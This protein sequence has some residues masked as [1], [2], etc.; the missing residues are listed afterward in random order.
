MFEVAFS[1][2]MCCS[3]VWSV[4]TNP[5]LPSMSLVSPAIRPGIRRIS[6]SVA[7]KNPNDGPPKSRRLPSVWPSPTAMSTPH[8]PGVFSSASGS[9]SHAQI[10]SAPACLA[11][12]AS[13]CQVLDRAEEVRLLHDHRADVVAELS[14]AVTPSLSGAST[15]SIPQAWASVRTHSREWGWT[16][17]EITKRFRSFVVLAT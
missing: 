14:R 7:A 3:R 17:R 11:S 12:S 13:A 15:T 4:S 8:S 1:R 9:G 5:R 16:P 2:R 10:V 6:A